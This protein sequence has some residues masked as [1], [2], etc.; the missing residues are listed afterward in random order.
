ML[1]ELLEWGDI[2]KEKNYNPRNPIA[3]VFSAVKEILKFADIN[4]TS[5][6]QL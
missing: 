2:V 1:H 3:T 6:T 4:G 5:Y